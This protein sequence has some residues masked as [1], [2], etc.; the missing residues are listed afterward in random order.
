MLK[1]PSA[2]RLWLHS[3][4]RSAQSASHSAIAFNSGIVGE[5][6]GPLLAQRLEQM[7]E[8]AQVAAHLLQG[9]DVEALD[10]LGDQAHVAEV[11]LGRVAGGRVPAL[12]QPAEGAQIPGANQQVAIG[13]LARDDLVDLRRELRDLGADRGGRTRNLRLGRHSGSLQSCCRE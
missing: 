9:D 1:S 12:G 8:R 3:L 5:Q 11:A 4:S 13:S 2:I 10:H 7:A 6:E